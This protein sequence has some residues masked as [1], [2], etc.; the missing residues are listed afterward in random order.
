MRKKIVAANWKLNKTPKESEDFFKQFPP[1]FPQGLQGD[2]V[3]FPATINLLPVKSSIDHAQIKN[4]FWGAQNCYFEKSGAFTGET[5]P[6]VLSQLGA[7]Y[8]LVGHSERRTLFKED[9]EMLAKKV[10]ALQ[11]EGITPMLCV[12]ESLREREENKTEAVIKN[13]LLKGLALATKEAPFA[14]AYEPVWAIGT[15]RVAE[16][17]QA[18]SAHQFLRQCLHE[19]FGIQVS[20][21]TSILYGGSVTGQNARE[22]GGLPNI[23][24]FLVGGASLKPDS[25]ASI[26]QQLI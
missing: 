10:K 2:V 7:T 1:I 22:L 4:L 21:N 8:T 14:I 25:F 11:Q 26:I 6:Q 12:G 23:D 3:I 17:H 13:Q 15:G 9:D 24:G 19:S 18:E 16:P 5:S 20:Q